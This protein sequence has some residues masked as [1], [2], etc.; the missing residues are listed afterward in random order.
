MSEIVSEAARLLG[1]LEQEASH[2]AIDSAQ[3]LPIIRLGLVTTLYFK[4]GHTLETKRRVEACFARFYEAFRPVLKWQLHKRPRKLGPVGFATCCRQILDSA[5]EEPFMWSIASGTSDEVAT[6]QLSVM[7]VAQGQADTDHSC[8]KMVLPWSFLVQ[9]EGAKQYEAWIRYLCAQVRAEHGYGGLACILPGECR[10]YLPL[11]YQ[12]AQQYIGLM[13]DAG[14]HIESLRLLHRIKGVAWYT[15]LGNPFVKRLGGND[16]LR[17]TLSRHSNIVFHAYDGGLI[18]RA[19]ALPDLCGRAEAPPRAYVAINKLIKPVRLQETGC[20]HPYLVTGLGFT[21][22]STAQWYARFDA[23]PPPAVKA[24]HPC[25]Q[26]GYWFSNARA[27][28]RRFFNKGEIMPAFEHV[29]AER[30]QWFWADEG[31]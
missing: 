20:L 22:E 18:I 8:L 30:T 24:G 15:V 17:G 16:L 11:E 25:P 1:K 31:Q 21:E 28:S 19:G 29:K 10:H 14:P 12:L 26:T 5:P 7:S 6:H 2:L 4:H 3:G 13:V 9:D 27:R 23:K